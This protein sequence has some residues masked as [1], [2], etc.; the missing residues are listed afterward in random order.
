MFCF[1]LGY[2]AKHCGFTSG[3]SRVLALPQTLDQYDSFLIS[4][5]PGAAGDPIIALYGDYFRKRTQPLNCVIYLSSTG[6]YGN[7]DGAWVDETTPPQKITD[8]LK[9]E[10]QWQDLFKDIPLFIFRLSGI[11]GPE[12]NSMQRILEG[13]GQLI[14]KP[15][16]MFSRIHV[17]DICRVIHEAVKHPE[18]AGIYNISD[19][20]PAASDEVTRYAYELLGI[21]PPSVTPFEEAEI[22]PMLRAFYADS[23]RVNN[24]KMKGAFGPLLYPTYREGLCSLK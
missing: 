23:K 11:Y 3:T 7:H 9:A 24:E 4:V 2:V 18:K 22:S 5:P 16:H 10:Q 15:N 21:T 17:A 6:I 20:L 19:D 13:K 8:R 14:H 1:G 12:R